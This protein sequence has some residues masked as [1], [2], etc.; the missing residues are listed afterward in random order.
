MDQLAPDF[1]CY[2]PFWSKY[3]R[4]P[5]KNRTFKIKL[6]LSRNLKGSGCFF[7]NQDEGYRIKLGNTLAMREK[8]NQNIP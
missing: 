3:V 2:A 8:K 4:N 6:F 7:Q 1:R 5:I